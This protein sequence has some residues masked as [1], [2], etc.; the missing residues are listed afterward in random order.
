MVG[1]MIV[2]AYHTNRNIWIRSDLELLATGANC[3]V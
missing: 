3:A 2:G 1:L